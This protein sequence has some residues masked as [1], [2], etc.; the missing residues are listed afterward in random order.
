MTEDLDLQKLIAA[1]H[2]STWVA[3]VE[4][5]AEPPGLLDAHQKLNGVP[6]PQRVL[7]SPGFISTSS[8]PA[9]PLQATCIG[10]LWEVML[11]P[12]V[13]HMTHHLLIPFPCNKGSF[14]WLHRLRPTIRTSDSSQRT[15]VW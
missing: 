5:L 11:I 2:L 8:R 14:S 3:E 13:T 1:A 6:K 12:H 4:L 9:G 15:P 10:W 7:G